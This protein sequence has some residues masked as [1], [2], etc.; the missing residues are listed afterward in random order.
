[1]DNVLNL[2]RKNRVIAI[3]R[4]VPADSICD[5][6]QAIIDYIKRFP[7]AALESCKKG[8]VPVKVKK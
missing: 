7:E 1:M 5:L 2:I 3:A 4:Y 8:G 6:A